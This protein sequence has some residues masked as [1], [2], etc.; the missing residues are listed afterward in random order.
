L[1]VSQKGSKR[2][3]GKPIIL[4]RK[5]VGTRQTQA[6]TQSCNLAEGGA[7]AR[8]EIHGEENLQCKK[9]RSSSS[10]SRGVEKIQAA[11]YRRYGKDIKAVGA[12]WISFG[13]SA[14]GRENSGIGPTPRRERTRSNEKKVPLTRLQQKRAK[15]VGSEKEILQNVPK[16]LTGLKK[17]FSP[18]VR[19]GSAIGHRKKNQL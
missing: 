7:G 19:T 3:G 6:S 14:G 1:D 8:G 15:P 16:P 11:G 12:S 5:A 2:E 4:K 17:S 10:K 18:E 13:N 9:G